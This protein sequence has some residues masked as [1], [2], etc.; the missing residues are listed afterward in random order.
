MGNLSFSWES[1]DT[2]VWY[3]SIPHTIFK[4]YESIDPSSIRSYNKIA[5]STALQT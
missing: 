3:M 2:S 1:G 4:W 5:T